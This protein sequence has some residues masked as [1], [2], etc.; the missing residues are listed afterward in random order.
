[1]IKAVE[2]ILERRSQPRDETVEWE[3]FMPNPPRDG[4]VHNKN[5][6]NCTAG[7]YTTTARPTPP[8]VISLY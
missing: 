5:E 4:S 7:Y 2:Q 1:M 3:K 8:T 6:H